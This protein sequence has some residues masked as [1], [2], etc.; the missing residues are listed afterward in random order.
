MESFFKE[1]IGSLKT[2]G[3]VKPSSKYLIRNCLKGI[4]YSRAETIIEFGTGNGCFTRE[5]AKNMRPNTSL[6]SFEVN[7]KFHAYSSREF[8]TQKNVQILNRSALDFDKVLRE[9]SVSQV[10]YIISSLPLTLFKKSDTQTIL[11]KVSTYLKK[12]GCFV[13]Y[14]Y[15]LSNYLQLRR[16][17]DAIHIGVTI[18][19]FPPAVIY[20]CSPK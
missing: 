15:S 17:F 6:Y 16:A 9:D 7:Q 14:Q 8:Q 3:T 20:T 19:N 12:E 4:D 11:S 1:A 10:D 2:S 13:Q 5:I 18:R